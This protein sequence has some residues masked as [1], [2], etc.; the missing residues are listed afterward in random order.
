MASGLKVIAAL[1]AIAAG[2]AA[3]FAFKKP[4]YPASDPISFLQ[5]LKTR[6]LLPILSVNAW[7]CASSSPYVIFSPL[8]VITAVLFLNLSNC[9]I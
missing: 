3:I 5:R 8:S 9:H 2:A 1:G 6:H 4:I 7:Q